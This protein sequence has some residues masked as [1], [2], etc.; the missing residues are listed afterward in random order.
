MLTANFHTHST[1]CDGT[2]TPGE[3]VERAL[4]LGFTKLGFSGHVDIDPV[5]DVD[6]YLREI[7]ALQEAYR[8]RIEILCGGEVDTFYPDP[9]RGGFDYKIGSNHFLDVGAERPVSVDEAEEI[10]LRLLRESF[11]GD[12]YRLTRAYYDRAARI[13]DLTRCDI[14]GHFDLVTKYNNHLGLIDEEDPR[15]LGPA[16]EALD[17][18]L[19]QNVLFEINTRIIGRGRIYPNR[20]FLKRIRERGGEIVISSDA[21]SAA[22]LNKGFP[23]AAALAKACG[24]DHTNYL[25]MEGGKLSILPVG[26]D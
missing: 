16:M 23:E 25:S 19:S 21:H 8:D 18:L 17:C 3:M 9:L 10:F 13:Y 26:L 6:A 4:E 11:G 1:F 22:E 12:V 7:R 5:M 14:I 2:S 15:Y 24:F 20:T